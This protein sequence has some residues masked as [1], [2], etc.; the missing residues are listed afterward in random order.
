MHAKRL[1]EELTIG[2]SPFREFFSGKEETGAFCV[3]TGV[4]EEEL[5]AKFRGCLATVQEK[6][7]TI[8]VASS[9]PGFLRFLNKKESEN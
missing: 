7:A 1:G 2:L 3:G 9:R 6:N 8:T 5:L 4:L